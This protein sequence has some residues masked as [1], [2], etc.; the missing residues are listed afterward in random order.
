MKE[1][2]IYANSF[3]APFFSDSST[4]F[5]KAK[6]AVDALRKFAKSYKHPCGLYAAAAYDNADSY[7]K[8]GKILGRWLCN[9]A[10]YLLDAK[11]TSF[12]QDAPGVFVLDDKPVKIN[13]PKKGR[14][15][16]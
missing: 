7:H 11:Y 1:Y 12:R 2:F 5:V 8:D 14:V 6:S 3:A 13:K 16:T 10:R 4:H 15:S 9:Q